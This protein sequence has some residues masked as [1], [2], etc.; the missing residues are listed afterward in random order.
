MAWTN[1][2]LGMDRAARE[3]E[4]ATRGTVVGANVAG[5]AASRS[6]V[7]NEGEFASAMACLASA[8]I[9]LANS[10]VGM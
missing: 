3:G 2:G 8:A 1:W 4:D 6:D 10:L 9:A 7:L 5:N